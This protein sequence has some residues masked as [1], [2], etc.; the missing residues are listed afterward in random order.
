VH[1]LYGI[2]IR[3]PWPIADVSPVLGPWDVEFVEGDAATFAD[4]AA[5]IPRDQARWWTQVAAL[6]DGS[7]YRRWTNLFE[8][9][10]APD[11]R[12][13]QVRALKDANHEAFLAY[14]LVDA[15]SFSMVRLGREPLHATAV[16]TEHGAVAFLGQSGYGKSTLGAAFVHGGCPLITDDMLILT[17]DAGLYLAH[18]G[19]P[20]I[21]L[22]PAI[23]T[24]IFG[25]VGRCAP[26]NPVTEKLIIR[27]TQHQTVRVPQLLRALYLICEDGHGRGRGPRLGALSPARALPGV[28]AG[29]TSHWSRDPERLT[30]QFE[31]V[32]RL[33]QRVPIK[34]LAYPRNI[35]DMF[36]VRDAV[37]ADLARFAA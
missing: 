12:R 21:K 13:I 6:P 30:R 23:A 17:P 22:F 4:A 11:G 34:T 32:T 27:L 18:P 10:V 5:H 7:R 26:M 25:E 9:L 35:E 14:L 37:L 15:L 16:L 36:H 2:S 3:T 1:H 19:P 31:F 20:R 8:F 24:R 33:V 29:A 28:L